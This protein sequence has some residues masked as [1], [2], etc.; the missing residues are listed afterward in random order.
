MSVQPTKPV[1]P[2]SGTSVNSNKNFMFFLRIKFLRLGVFLFLVEFLIS[3][4]LLCFRSMCSVYCFREPKGASVSL[5]LEV[6]NTF[7]ISSSLET[8]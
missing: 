8:K 7:L 6:G 4:F 5:S 3:S 2:L 1:S